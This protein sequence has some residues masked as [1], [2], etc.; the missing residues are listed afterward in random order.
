MAS[1]D[2]SSAGVHRL[3]HGTQADFEHFSMDEAAHFGLHFGTL[4]QARNKAGRTG[5]VLAVDLH[6]LR[7]L[8]L[9]DLGTWSFEILARELDGRGRAILDAA[10]YERCWKHRDPDAALRATLLR[11][12]YD[13]IVYANEVEGGGDSWI[14]LSADILTVVDHDVCRPRPVER[15]G[16]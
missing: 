14:A 9:P 4:E 12:G 7:P 1:V 15:S 6:A 8:R 10:D 16:G 11:H 5:R 13:T 2:G 3:Y